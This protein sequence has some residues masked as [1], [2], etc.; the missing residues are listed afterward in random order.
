MNLLLKLACLLVY[1]LALAKLAGL[2]PPD[3]MAHT[4]TIALAILVAHVAE[5]LFG[6]LHWKPLAD[7]QAREQAG[8]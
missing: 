8:A 2:V 6:L 5:L 1:L 4:P 3:V 7:A